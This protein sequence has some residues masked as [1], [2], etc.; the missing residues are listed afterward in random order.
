MSLFDSIRSLFV[1]TPPPTPAELRIEIKAE[2]SDIQRQIKELRGEMN[3]SESEAENCLETGD[4]VGFNLIFETFT[5][6]EAILTTYR[7][8]EGLYNGY[9]HMV[10]L[11][12][13]FQ[14]L[15][16]A[17]EKI[18]KFDKLYGMDSTTMEQVAGQ[19]Q[20][21]QFR[22][23][24]QVKNITNLQENLRIQQPDNANRETFRNRLQSKIDSRRISSGPIGISADP[25]KALERERNRE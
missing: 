2:K 24:E 17:G 1:S 4:E 5:Q 18:I 12:V 8:F 20:K 11:N 7:T 15:S 22:I 6:Q 23:Q 3:S 10:G 21:S 25:R 13:H 9:E 19:L 16:K 14:N